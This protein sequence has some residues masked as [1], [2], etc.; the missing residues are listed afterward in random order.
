MLQKNV[1]G[2]IVTG[3]I[4]KDV[5]IGWEG[6]MQQAIMVKGKELL[7][8]LRNHIMKQHLNGKS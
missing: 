2:Q 3:V 4:I 1:L 7:E 6:F 8:D 5:A